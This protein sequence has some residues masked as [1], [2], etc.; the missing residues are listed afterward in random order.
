MVCKLPKF[1]IPPYSLHDGRICCMEQEN[2][3]LRLWLESG[4]VETIPP[5]RQ[6]SGSV[7]F[8]EMDW[9]AS[10]VYL[11][12][13]GNSRCGN[14]GEFHGEKLL[15]QT[16]LSLFGKEGLDVYDEVFGWNQVKLCGMLLSDPEVQECIL[17]IRYAG[18]ML[19]DIEEQQPDTL[20]NPK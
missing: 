11:L 6:V 14:V 1:P 5:Y 19:F 3:N 8:T 10:Y 7:Q 18:E 20:R 16:F 15:L 13:Y 4:F 9:G 17:E 2:E 12:R